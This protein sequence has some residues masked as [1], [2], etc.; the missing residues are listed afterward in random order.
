MLL[1]AWMLAGRPVGVWI[2]DGAPLLFFW[3]VHWDGNGRPD[4]SR[5]KAKYRALN[6]RTRRV[7]SWGED[8]Y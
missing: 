2:E 5:P 3:A 8:R 7:A 1:V 6:G 4:S